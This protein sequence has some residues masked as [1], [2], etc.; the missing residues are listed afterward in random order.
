MT[1][2]HADKLTE[3]GITAQFVAVET[4]PDGS[5]RYQCEIWRNGAPVWTGPYTQGS[6]FKD[7]PAAH[8]IF[9]AVLM[10]ATAAMDSTNM[11]DFAS[12]FGYRCDRCNEV[13]PEGRR[14]W[15]ACCETAQ[16]FRRAFT[17][18]ELDDLREAFSDY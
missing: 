5:R 6:A 1:T 16:A 18:V 14:V 12:E 10:D 4:R 9:W 7:R 17:E 3:H 13:S 15:F 8:D 2:T 11:D